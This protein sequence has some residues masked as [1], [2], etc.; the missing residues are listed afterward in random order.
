M[1]FD[2][3]SNFFNR[4]PAMTMLVGSVNWRRAKKLKLT[5]SASGSTNLEDL[6]SSCFSSS[7]NPLAAHECELYHH[8]AG[9]NKCN[10][11][12][13]IISSPFLKYPLSSF[14]IILMASSMSTIFRRRPFSGQS[15][16]TSEMYKGK[17]NR[18]T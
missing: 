8:D 10:P 14:S 1:P 5:G 3:A 18:R 15:F 9:F 4:G 13:L 17:S 2:F 11:L 16:F 6:M 7:F 12:S